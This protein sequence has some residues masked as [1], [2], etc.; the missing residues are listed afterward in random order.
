MFVHRVIYLDS[1]PESW[2]VP[3]SDN[4]IAYIVD[5]T[6]TPDLLGVGRKSL[7]VD[8]YIKKEVTL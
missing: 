2:D 7:T 3:A 6:E 1:V 5:L 4:C 8:G